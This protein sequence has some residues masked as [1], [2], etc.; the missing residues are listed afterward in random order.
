MA[1]TLTSRPA[2]TPDQRATHRRSRLHPLQL[3]A[4]AVIAVLAL[5]TAGTVGYA[6]SGPATPGDTSAEAGFA[7]DMQAHH[8]QAVTMSMIVRDDTSDPEVRAVAYD[9][10]LGQQQQEGQMFDWLAQWGLTQASGRPAM[11]WMND[12]GGVMHH[13]GS[14]TPGSGLQLLPDGRMPGMATTADVSRL[15]QL[16]E[17]PAEVFWLQLMINHHRGGVA[18]A[19]MALDMTSRPEVR[20][21]AQVIVTNQEAEI[22]QMTQ[23]LTARGAAPA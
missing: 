22:E 1:T 15:S 2:A 11:A 6:A 17:R 9:I 13:G 7:R 23:M 14:A 16:R 12:R 8:A 18:M 4:L 20:R 5:A 10:A 19:R 21:L 3:A